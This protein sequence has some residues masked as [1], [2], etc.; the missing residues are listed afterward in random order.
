[1]VVVAVIA[2]AAAVFVD[3]VTFVIVGI[4]AVNIVSV[5]MVTVNMVTVIGYR[6]KTAD[7]NLT[8]PQKT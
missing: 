2:V 5:N 1:M 7:L 6:L 8:S 3:D 4:V